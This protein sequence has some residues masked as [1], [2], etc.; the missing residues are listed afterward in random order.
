MG[1]G[2]TD[3]KLQ[4]MV[5][6]SHYLDHE[7]EEKIVPSSYAIVDSHYKITSGV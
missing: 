6:D 2:C 5:V 3:F 7:L 4:G 1:P